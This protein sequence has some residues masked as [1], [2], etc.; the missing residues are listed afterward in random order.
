MKPDDIIDIQSLNPSILVHLHYATSDNFTG[1][2]VP[3]YHT[4]KAF[5]CEKA[6]LKLDLIQKELSNDR[7]SLII[8]DAYRPMKAVNFFHEW[9]HLKSLGEKEKYYPAITK[10][11]IFTEGFIAKRSRHA[12]ASAV[13]LSLYHLDQKALLDMGTIFDYFGEA[14]HTHS[15]NITSTQ[16]KNRL[17]LLELMQ[18]HGFS[19]FDKEWWHF[20]FEDEP[21]KETYFDFDIV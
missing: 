14:S 19:N 20:N 16:Y 13:D 6:A 7:L 21:Y 1:V 17:Y 15:K 3:G 4:H 10:E 9:R 8:F 18:K 5:I 2:P 12:R 11:E